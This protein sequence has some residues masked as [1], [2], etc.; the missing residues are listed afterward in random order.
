MICKLWEGELS[1]SVNTIEVT[2]EN[3]EKSG[4]F[5]FMS[6]KKSPGYAQKLKWLKER[7]TEG[8]KIKMLQ[9]PERGFIEYIPGEYAWRPVKAEGYMVIHCLWV[10]GKSRGKGFSRLLLDMCEQDARSAGMNGVVAVSSQGSWLLG[11]ELFIDSGYTA[12][13][14]AA[15]SFTLLVKKF[16]DAPDPSFSRDWNKVDKTDEKSMIIFR[17]NQCPYIEDATR[18]F[19]DATIKR[20]VPSRVV[21]LNSARE[22]Q[23]LSPSAYGTFGVTVAGELFSYC[24][25]TESQIDQKWMEF[26]KTGLK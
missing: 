3:V 7:F 11:K 21:S 5:C 9:L 18:I 10:V 13:A 24:Y 14:C 15:P 4:F 17:T 26:D 2:L 19:E 8:L 25:L 6:K 1:T 16:K 20:G 23:E 22:V 12:V